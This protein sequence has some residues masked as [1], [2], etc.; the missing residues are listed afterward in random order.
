[1]GAVASQ[2]FSTGDV[3]FTDTN[4]K[5]WTNNAIEWGV[6]SVSVE[7]MSWNC[8]LDRVGLSGWCWHEMSE[9]GSRKQGDRSKGHSTLCL[10][11]VEM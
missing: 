2:T 3:V 10:G 11:T 7:A 9:Q 1:M 8:R 6:K 5:L 4:T